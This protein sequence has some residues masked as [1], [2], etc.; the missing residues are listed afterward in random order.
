MTFSPWHSISPQSAEVGRTT[1]CPRRSDLFSN[2]V[3]RAMFMS[4]PGCRVVGAEVRR[5]FRMGRYR[6]SAAIAVIFARVPGL[7]RSD[8]PGTSAITVL[9]ALLQLGYR[10]ARRRLL[11][12]EGDLV[13]DLD[14]LEH[15]R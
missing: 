10:V 12:L 15:R 7:V 13:A 5:S 3:R 11:G 8:H 9:L 6:V 1:T 14:L 4:R 2:S